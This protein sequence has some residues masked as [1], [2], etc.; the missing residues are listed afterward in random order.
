[1]KKDC[2]G[3]GKF[4]EALLKSCKISQKEL[5]KKTGMKRPSISKIIHEKTQPTIPTAIRLLQALNGQI[6]F[7]K[8]EI[9]DDNTTIFLDGFDFVAESKN[10]NYG[11]DNV[12]LGDRSKGRIVADLP[13]YRELLIKRLEAIEGKIDDK[14]TKELDTLKND[15][16]NDIKEVKLLHEKLEAKLEDKMNTI[17]L[18]LDLI[19]EKL[20]K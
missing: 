16:K 15:V 19:L 1:M 14:I 18:T 2:M 13:T 5:E 20:K 11:G 10:I 3:F 4:I 9:A 7:K 12:I 8:K 6:V 17:K